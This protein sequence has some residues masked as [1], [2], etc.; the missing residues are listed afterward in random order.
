VGV[1]LGGGG[2]RIGRRWEEVGGGGGRI[3][4]R[5]E[6]VGGGRRGRRYIGLGGHGRD[7]RCTKTCK[8]SVLFYFTGRRKRGRKSFAP[9]AQDTKRMELNLMDS[10]LY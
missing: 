3:G 9:V 6:E 2:G 10:K 1:G 8:L 4:R 7:W 5:W